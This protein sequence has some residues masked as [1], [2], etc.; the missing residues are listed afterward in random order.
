MLRPTV[1]CA[2]AP[3]ALALA[4]LPLA[5]EAACPT[6]PGPTPVCTTGPGGWSD[7]RQTLAIPLSPDFH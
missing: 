5:A 6:T 1:L 4:L 7:G 3:L 2:T